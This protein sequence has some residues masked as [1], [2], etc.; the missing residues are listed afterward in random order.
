MIKKLM[1]ACAAIVFMAACARASKNSGNAMTLKIAHYKVP[2]AGESVQLCFV[3]KKENGDKEFFYDQIEGFNFQWGYDY[4]LSV[5]K[6]TI[7]LPKADMSSNSYKLVK[8]LKKEKVSA[9]VEFELP[10]KFNDEVV[11]Q[12]DKG[13]CSYF[14]E[15]RIS[16]G[17]NSCDELAKASSAIFKYAADGATLVLVRMKS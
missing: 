2:C 1:Y 7:K 16:T 9:G 6:K 4:E 12:H 17:N 15:I 14:N 10:V 3:I 13:S 5:E 8:I 11:V